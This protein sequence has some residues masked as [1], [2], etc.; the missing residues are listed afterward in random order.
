MK[1]VKRNHPATLLGN[2]AVEEMIVSAYSK[3]KD[4]V[5]IGDLKIP[6]STTALCGLL[7]SREF[8]GTAYVTYALSQWN[9]M[10]RVYWKLDRDV[11][12]AFLRTD[13]PIEL[14][15]E[16]P[17]LPHQAMYIEVPEGCFSVH[18]EVSGDHDAWGFY[19]CEDI[20]LDKNDSGLD[21]WVPAI[22]MI[23]VG[24]IRDLE[25]RGGEVT[26]DDALVFG[27]ATGIHDR[28]DIRY[29]AVAN[30]W[31][32]TMNLLVA[33]QY[34]YVAAEQV[35]ST[36]STKKSPKKIKKA[37]RRGDISFTRIKLS[38]IGKEAAKGFS[39]KDVS[40][41]VTR[42]LRR[43]H[44]RKVWVLDPRGVSAA[45]TKVREDGVSMYA[46]ARWIAPTWVGS[47]EEKQRIA[48][49]SV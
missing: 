43:G 37:E 36:S 32:L 12:D 49:V 21:S 16:L 4:G 47:G 35:S 34:G 20:A 3:M 23:G 38:S 1:L 46:V 11:V 29:P 26:Y 28:V 31:K 6:W 7:Q 25:D 39:T 42:H 18:N 24:E 33:L 10:G 9:R 44:W 13:P 19:L 22:T 15:E 45:G 8:W 17:K 48:K 5:T 27:K 14:L 2:K 40:K 30:I 41:G